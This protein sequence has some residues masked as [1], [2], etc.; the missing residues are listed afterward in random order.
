MLLLNKNIY[1]KGNFF[2]NEYIIMN[3]VFYVSRL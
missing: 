1:M 3:N 2:L